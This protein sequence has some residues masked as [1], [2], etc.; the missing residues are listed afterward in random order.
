M[1]KIISHQKLWHLWMHFLEC[2]AISFRSIWY[3]IKTYLKC[4]KTPKSL[5]K[6]AKKLKLVKI[7]NIHSNTLFLIISYT[8]A[9]IPVE[10]ITLSMYMYKR[11]LAVSKRENIGIKIKNVKMHLMIPF[12]YINS[13]M[14]PTWFINYILF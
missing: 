12:F 3:S 2:L 10:Y 8:I 7:E 4:N 11:A 5:K 1:K 9:I 13:H 14:I 6:N